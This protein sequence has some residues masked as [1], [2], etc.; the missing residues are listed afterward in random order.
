MRSGSTIGIKSIYEGKI[1]EHEIDDE[2]RKELEIMKQS[3]KILK[4]NV[5]DSNIDME[6]VLRE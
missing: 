4:D 5:N 6:E 3:G 1:I 2:L